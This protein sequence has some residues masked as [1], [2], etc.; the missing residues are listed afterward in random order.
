MKALLLEGA[1]RKIEGHRIFPY[2]PVIETKLGDITA[3][4]AHKY[5]T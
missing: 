2:L 4:C 1:P 5:S 3:A